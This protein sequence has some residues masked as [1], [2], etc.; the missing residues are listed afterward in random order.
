[1]SEKALQLR[2]ERWERDDLV[3]CRRELV[4]RAVAFW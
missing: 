2:F 3:D 4:E 1:V